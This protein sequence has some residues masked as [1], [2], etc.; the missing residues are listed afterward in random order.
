MAPQCQ[1]TA[2]LYFC[3]RF[4]VNF[5]LL[6]GH[7]CCCRP[8]P[9]SADIYDPRGENT[10]AT[11]TVSSSAYCITMRTSISL[12]HNAMQGRR[13]GRV[14]SAMPADGGIYAAALARGLLGFEEE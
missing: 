4:A 8:A 1:E 7:F 9:P 10:C 13:T 11:A 14:L 3:W 12:A 6:H 5:E 2:S